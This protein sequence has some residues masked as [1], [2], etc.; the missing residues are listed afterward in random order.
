MDDTH[1][2]NIEVNM[3]GRILPI[4]NEW[5]GYCTINLNNNNN[6][7]NNN[8]YNNN[9]NNN[10]NWNLYSAISIHNMFK[11]AAHCHSLK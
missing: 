3:Y 8:N 11:G 6:N 7:Y 4:Y 1:I 10:N 9:N 5:E 2:R